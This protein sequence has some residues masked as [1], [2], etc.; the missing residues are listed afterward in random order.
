MPT[1][2]ADRRLVTTVAPQALLMMN[3]DF[4]MQAADKVAEQ[5]LADQLPA[6]QAGDNQRLTRLYA[7]VYG[8]EATAAER[9][10]DAAFL[11]QVEQSLTAKE[12]DAA[13]R[14]QQAWGVLCH[15]V[16]AANEFLYID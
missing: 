7:L 3:S 5:L 9:Q 1:R 14:R 12:P 13:K 8:R 2:S 11:A 15:T 6:D 16:I 10:A 4:V